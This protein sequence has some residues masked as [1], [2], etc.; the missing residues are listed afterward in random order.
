M[1]IY[2][3]YLCVLFGLS[4]T[5]AYA[6]KVKLTG[7]VTD[8]LNNPLELANVIAVNTAKNTMEAYAITNANGKYQMLITKGQS[9]LLRV[10]YLGYK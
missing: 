6:Q 5:K 2:A 8:S 1:R 10:S 9:Y 3:L 7:V 4:V